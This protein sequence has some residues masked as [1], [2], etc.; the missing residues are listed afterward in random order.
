[1]F[2]GKCNPSFFFLA[3]IVLGGSTLRKRI[4]RSR[5]MSTSNLAAFFANAV[6]RLSK[7]MIKGREATMQTAELSTPTCR[8]TWPT[9]AVISSLRTIVS[10]GHSQMANDSSSRR[11]SIPNSS[12]S[13]CGLEQ[14]ASAGWHH[15]CWSY[16]G[17]G[18]KQQDTPK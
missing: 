4:H 13:G 18:S 3:P 17:A 2:E 12:D 8:Y 1:M 16:V 9:P 15:P 11:N 10:P 6:L 14:F 5:N 7:C